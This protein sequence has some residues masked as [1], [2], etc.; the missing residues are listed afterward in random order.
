MRERERERER[1][2]VGV[3][4]SLYA[5]AF[6]YVPENLLV[7]LISNYIPEYNFISITYFKL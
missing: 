1:E 6:V 3:C 7:L 2:S 4:M 5:S